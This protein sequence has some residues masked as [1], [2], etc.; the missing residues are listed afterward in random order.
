M[1]NKNKIT[2]VWFA[3]S[4][5]CLIMVMQSKFFFLL[6][7]GLTGKIILGLVISNAFFGT[8]IGGTLIIMYFQSVKENQNN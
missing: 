4:L 7:F 6:D 1:D 2:V 3:F 5:V 8:L